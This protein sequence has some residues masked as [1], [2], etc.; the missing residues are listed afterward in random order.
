MRTPRRARRGIALGVLLFATAAACRAVP[1][2]GVR[3]SVDGRHELV[4]VAEGARSE[5]VA[6]ARPFRRMLVSWNVRTAGDVAFDAL[7]RVEHEGRWSPWLFVGSW[8]DTRIDAR[9]ERLTAFD[10]GRIATDEFIGEHDFER[11]QIR[12]ETRPPRDVSGGVT[13]C[14]SSSAT[15]REDEARAR[16][17]SASVALELPAFSQREQDPELAARICSPTSLAMVLGYHGVDASP[18]EVAARAY[19]AL[20][21]IYG[22]W[23]RSIQAAYSFGVPGYLARFDSWRP[24]EAHLAAGRPVILSIRVEAGGLV[25][26][27]YDATPGH[28][29]VVVGF[30]GEGG[31]LVHD[32][33][34]ESAATVRRVYSR[35]EL[36]RAWFGH[37]GTAYVIGDDGLGADF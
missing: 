27:P 9:R 8:G 15:E 36:G 33:A 5:P 23:P 22:N 30:D 25:G 10:G 21:D 20:H 28:L 32:P 18:S 14:F 35:D 16:A 11:A 1:T 6:A 17:A 2:A 4:H 29:L 3:R 37:G 7:V 24:V 13:F 34:A 12:F 26:A 19:D 31:V